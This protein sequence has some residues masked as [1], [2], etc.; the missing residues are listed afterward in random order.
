MAALHARPLTGRKR[1]VT[2]LWGLNGKE[3][4]GG[5]N[6]IQRAY[7]A[8][9]RSGVSYCRPASNHFLNMKGKAS[10]GFY[11]NGVAI[12][13]LLGFRKVSYI[14]MFYDQDTA[15]LNRSFTCHLRGSKAIRVLW[16]R[17]PLC[18]LNTQT[19]FYFYFFFHFC[20][21]QEL[22]SCFLISKEGEPKGC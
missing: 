1:S 7:K 17:P 4:R 19:G 5:K 22:S 20:N 10:F 12:T 8:N 13:F 16:H 3:R 18:V 21:C 6:A 15:W 2:S 11:S 14:W 9:V